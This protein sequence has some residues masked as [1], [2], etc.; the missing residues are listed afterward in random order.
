MTTSA[1]SIPPDFDPWDAEIVNGSAGRTHI[2][3]G[4]RRKVVATFTS[5][6]EAAD[7]LYGPPEPPAC[8]ICDGI[9][10]GYPGAGPCPLEETGEDDPRERE[11]WALEDALR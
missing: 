6:S 3:V 2:V 11:L 1:L 10:H 8:S 4:A 9:G 5:A 7:F